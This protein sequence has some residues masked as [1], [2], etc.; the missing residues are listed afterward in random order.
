MYADYLTRHWFQIA[1]GHAKQ[2][3]YCLRHNQLSD[4]VNEVRL[5]AV[6]AAKL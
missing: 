5:C 6:N 2:R 3:G 4:L 1:I